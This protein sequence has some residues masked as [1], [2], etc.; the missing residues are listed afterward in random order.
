MRFAPFV[1][2]GAAL[3]SQ[4]LYA[5][6]CLKLVFD[7]YCL[8]GPAPTHN[9]DNTQFSLDEQ[10]HISL[11]ERRLEPGD[12]LSFV[13]WRSELGALYGRGEDHSTLPRF[14]SSRS[15]RARAVEQGR[16]QAAMHWP[17]AGWRIEL[18]WDHLDYL[19]LRY[20]VVPD[21]APEP[22]RTNTDLSL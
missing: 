3:V 15:S 14:A 5:D 11:V 1:L 22:P 8:G 16:G 21:A 9:L 7:K 12:W 6:D 17:Q 13:Q 20:L 18:V 4:N 2:L 19:R 10:G